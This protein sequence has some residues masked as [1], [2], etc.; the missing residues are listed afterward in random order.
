MNSTDKSGRGKIGLRLSSQNLTVA[1]GSRTTLELTLHNR[2]EQDDSYAI[3]L[4]GIPRA[5]IRSSSPVVALVAGAEKTINLAIHPP[6]SPQSEAGR[7]PVTVRVASRSTPSDAV[8]MDLTLTVTAYSKFDVD[9]HPVPLYRGQTGIVTVKNLGNYPEQYTLT[10]E[11]PADE[12]AVDPVSSQQVKIAPGKSA[13]IEFQ[14]RTR[15]FSGILGQVDYPFSVEVCSSEDES[16]TVSGRLVS[17]GVIPVWALA[18][19]AV[20][21][22]ILLCVVLLVPGQL[23]NR[24]AQATR[25]AAAEQTA[26]ALEVL[27]ADLD[28]D[29]LSSAQEIELGTNPDNPDSDGDGLFDGREIELGTQPLNPDT[30]GDGLLDGDEILRGTNPLNPDSDGDNLT[31]GQEV[32]QFNT[33]PTNPDTDGDGLTDDVDPEPNALPTPTPLPTE[34][35]VPTETPLPTESPAPTV[36]PAA[37]EAPNLGVL[38]FESDRDGNPEIYL[39]DLNS[40]QLTR[41]TNN[42]ATDTQPVWSPDGSRLAFTSDRENNQDIFLIN[43]D[44]SG[45]LNL[46]ANPAPD[47]E[48]A[49]SPDGEWMAFT[50][51]RDG[52]PEIYILNIASPDTIRLTDNPAAD[53]HPTWLQGGWLAFTTDRDGNQEIFVVN[54][55]SGEELNI[56]LQPADDLFPVASPSGEQL[57]F[58]SLRDGNAEIYFMNADGSAQRNLTANPAED[59]FPTWSSNGVWI[60]FTTTRDGNAEIYLMTTDGQEQVNITNN[61]AND[62]LPSWFSP[63]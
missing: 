47:Y 39:L 48:P 55:E 2:G 1:P 14:A 12:I 35:P 51:E 46:T 30:D 23:A 36:A 50:S 4:D 19:G 37:T 21:I 42:A 38:A 63:P 59:F 17:R 45:L 61:G 62:R 41:L 29:G 3:T 11:S 18:L 31:D 16:Q 6:R 15:L 40:L 58:T 53:F 33:S 20:A 5:W 43:R 7:V 24:S 28:N 8:E 52:N 56:S 27:N 34:T 60:A 49:W 22:A 9:L 25:Q 26:V 10:W 57:V 13:A 44:A 54:I 32:F